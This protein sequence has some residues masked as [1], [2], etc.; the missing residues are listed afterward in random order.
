VTPLPR[1]KKALAQHF[2]RDPGIL[3]KI[4]EAAGL[5]PE[6]TVLEIGPG[7]GD[8]TALLGERVRR[9]VAVEIDHALCDHLRERFAATPRIEIVQ[10][11]IL[12]YPLMPLGRFKVVANI[13]YYLT[14]PILFHLLGHRGQIPSLTLLLQKEVARRIVAPPG[15]KEY[16]ALSVAVQFYT[17]ARLC[18]TV[19][20]GSFT[21]APKVDSAVVHLAVRAKPAVSV[22]DEALFFRIVRA[23]FGQRRKTL[24][25]ALKPL[26]SEETLARAFAATGII[27]TRRGETLSLEEFGLLADAL[28]ESNYLPDST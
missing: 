3:A 7:P 11:D 15:G 19:A 16:G 8:M 14:A 20:A 21:P 9:V 23:A 26:F 2:L 6:D 13:P 4:V 24:R 25:N 12:E 18:F 10:G 1:P 5:T 22:R 17:E 28:I 27:P